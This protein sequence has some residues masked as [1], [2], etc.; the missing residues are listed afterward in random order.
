MIEFI[1]G[2]LTAL[3]FIPVAD[4]ITSTILTFFKMLKMKM[5]VKISQGNKTIN[6]MNTPTEDVKHIIGFGIPSGEENY[7]EDEDDDI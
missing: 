6:D 3:V 7:E 5:G 1:L 2:M 4:G